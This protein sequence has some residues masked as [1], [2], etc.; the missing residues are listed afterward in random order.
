MRRGREEIGGG[1]GK[2]G[3]RGD[4]GWGVGGGEIFLSR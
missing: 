1:G 2:G 3:E 4:G